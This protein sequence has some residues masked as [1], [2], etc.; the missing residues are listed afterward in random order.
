MCNI[1]LV[2]ISTRYILE[3]SQQNVSS[4]QKC[5]FIFA[6]AVVYSYHGLRNALLYEMQ[7]LMVW[8]V[9]YFLLE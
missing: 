1:D 3:K 9:Q 6:H 5:N 2:F 7:N 8:R 4:T